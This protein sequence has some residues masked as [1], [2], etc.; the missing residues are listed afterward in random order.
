VRSL[1]EGEKTDKSI[2]LHSTIATAYL[3]QKQIVLKEKRSRWELF[4]KKEIKSIEFGAKNEIQL[5]SIEVS[6]ECYHKE[7]DG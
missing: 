5:N 1:I 2:R 4:K 7:A 6:G 3:I